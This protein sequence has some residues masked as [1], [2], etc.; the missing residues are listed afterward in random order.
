M[1]KIAQLAMQHGSKLLF[2]DV[3]LSLASPNR[4]GLVGANG[5]GKST[6]LNILAGLEEPTLGEFTFPK[7]AVLGFLKQDH[8]LYEQ[9]RIIDVVIQGNQALWQALDEKNKLL[10]KADMTEKDGY[11]LATLEE[12]IAHENGYDA[13]ATAQSLLLGVGVPE[14]KHFQPLSSLSGGFKLRVLLAQVLY[15]A[16]DIMLLDEPTNHLDIMTIKWLENYLRQQYKGLLIFISHDKDFNN[17]VATHILDID[18]GEINLY[19]GNYTQF[20]L[21][22]AEVAEQRRVE[23]ESKEKEIA[24]MQAFV[25]RFKA[26]ASKARQAASRMKQIDR[27]SLPDI[28]RSSRIAPKFGFEI[29]RPPGKEVLHL[30]HISK[31]FTDNIVLFDV[32][33]SIKR[34]EKVAIIGHNGIGKST[35]L[36]IAMGLLTPDDGEYT[37]GF[38]THVGYF[39]QNVHD[40]FLEDKTLMA[41]LHD[42]VPGST[43]VQ[44]RNMLGRVLFTADEQTKSVTKLSGGECARLLLS[45]FMQLKSNVLVL[46]EP[47]NHLDIEA[48]DA[49]A[50]A[51]RSYK[52]TS[53][54]VSHNRDFVEKVATRVIA[55]TE[56]GVHDFPGN[57]KEY[58]KKVGDDYLSHDWLATQ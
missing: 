54:M 6:F 37:W 25:D 17:Q 2:D 49:L 42:E 23:K 53:I 30:E 47:T 11:R 5:T 10:E 34:G 58:I 3:N 19:H 22:K 50:K 56:R 40:Y 31:A 44:V 57:F 41:W 13:E 16:P 14:K 48:I 28:K 39:P 15:Q 9:D 21:K 51:L 33:L 29:Q 18:Y 27:I 8:Y 36:N 7:H 52:G 38:E 45:K 43:D 12:K 24:R 35:L 1:L 46:D 4:Y 26:K 32:S 55:I 20:E